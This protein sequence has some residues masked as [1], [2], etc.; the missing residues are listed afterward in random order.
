MHSANYLQSS[1][2]KTYVRNVRTSFPRGVIFDLDGTLV[3]NEAIHK[4]VFQEI[5]R[6][7]GYWLSH[8]EYDLQLCGLGDVEI[9]EYILKAAK[10]TRSAAE[11]SAQKLNR[12]L[13]LVRSGWLNATPGVITYIKN[14]TSQG[15]KLAIATNASKLETEIALKSVGMFDLINTI[16]SIEM[17]TRGKPAPDL[18]LRAARLMGL[19]SSQ[20]I[21]YEDSIH[22]V[23]AASSAG[24]QVVGVSRNNQNNLMLAG[25]MYEIVDFYDHDLPAIPDL[26]V[27]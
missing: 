17:V 20:C 11:I 2:P 12:Y 23:V 19:T 21:V 3:D 8:E 26:A 14:L 5:A 18:H 13:E 9:A 16:V 24:M 15:I 22:G 27:N 7:L 25:A 4:S 1:M 10:R 6:S